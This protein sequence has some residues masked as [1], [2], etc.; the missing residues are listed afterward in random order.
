MHVRISLRELFSL[1]SCS[2]TNAPSGGAEYGRE[3]GTVGH[4]IASQSQ[5]ADDDSKMAQRALVPYAI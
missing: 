1:F 5:E 3:F 2:N 4:S